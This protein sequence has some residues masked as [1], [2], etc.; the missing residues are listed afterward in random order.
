M[1]KEKTRRRRDPI[2]NLWLVRHA[3]ANKSVQELGLEPQLTTAGHEQAQALADSWPFEFAPDLFYC[4][5]LLR[6]KQTAEYLAQKFHKPYQIAKW[7]RESEADWSSYTVDKLLIYVD[8]HLP[9]GLGSEGWRDYPS[10]NMLIESYN[11]TTEGL[12]N[13]LFELGL[14][15]FNKSYLIHKPFDE[16]KPLNVVLLSHSGTTLIILSHL[17][18]LHPIF[19]FFHFTD[20]YTARFLIQFERWKDKALPVLVMYNHVP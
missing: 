13:M 7:L 14:K 12:D 6:A 4:S 2:L 8:K 16:S 5:N 1:I 17:F 3:E 20:S 10:P 18:N 11:R 15:R 19:T 9:K